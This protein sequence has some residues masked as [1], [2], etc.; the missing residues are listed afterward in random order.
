MKHPVAPLRLF[1]REVPQNF[2]FRSHST[3]FTDTFDQIE[4]LSVQAILAS[5]QGRTPSDPMTQN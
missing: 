4:E 2:F 3:T 5:D 1:G